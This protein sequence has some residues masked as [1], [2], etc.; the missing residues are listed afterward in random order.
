[1]MID[2]SLWF[3]F[4]LGLI[5]AAGAMIIGIGSSVIFSPFFILALKLDPLLAFASGLTI[6]IFSLSSGSIGYLRKKS[7]NFH[8]VKKL[9]ILTVPG[10]ILGV[11]LGRLLPTFFLKILLTLLLFYL[12]YQ[13]L[14]IVKKCNAKHPSCTG[15]TKKHEDKATNPLVRLTSFI[16][17]LFVGMVSS[18]LGEINEY[19]FIEKLN[20]PGPSAAGT[21][22]FLISASA[23][24]GVTAHILFLIFEN[25]LS[26]FSQ[27]F[28]LL[29]F[30]IPGV[31][32][33][34]QLGV[35]LARKFNMKFI[36]KY[37]GFLFFILAVLT[38]ITLL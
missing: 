20:L 27:I 17:G 3:M 31:I 1:M 30:T 21:S 6:E 2:V 32:L 37:L 23:F 10:T 34:A 7:V 33:G 13:F 24:V 28:S 36:I 11:F 35:L 14:F 15:I 18:G 38:I 19:N 4:P 12:S 5:I 8:V 22:I 29:L 25:N 26:A 9:I 16:G